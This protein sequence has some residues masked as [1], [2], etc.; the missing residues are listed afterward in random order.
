MVA[1]GDCSRSCRVS[2]ESMRPVYARGQPAAPGTLPSLRGQH[3]MI[4][5]SVRGARIVAKTKPTSKKNQLPGGK[6]PGGPPPPKGKS[7]GGQNV[8]QRMAKP[9]AK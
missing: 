7:G 3:G 2:S 9:K 1:S 6:G 4:V 8:V 5:E